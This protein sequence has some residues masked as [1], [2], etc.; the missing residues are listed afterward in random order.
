MF[1]TT[2]HPSATELEKSWQG[3][4]IPLDKDNTTDTRIM[5]HNVNG[6]TLKGTEGFDVFLNE[7]ALLH[8]DIQAISEHCLDTTQFRVLTTANEIAR[9]CVKHRYAL[10]LDSS[11]EPAL[12]QYKPGGTGM[13][14]LGP[15][16]SR[17]EPQGRGG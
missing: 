2:P 14:L 13:V 4:E 10:Q 1:P 15:V 17:L 6:L 3:D 11:S 12:H 7:Q 16:T 9:K 8:V 5:F